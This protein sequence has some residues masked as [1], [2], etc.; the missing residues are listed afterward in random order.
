MAERAGTVFETIFRR[1]FA[2]LQLQEVGGDM[3]RTMISK[4]RPAQAEQSD[5]GHA[6]LLRFEVSS[7]VER[8]L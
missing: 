3:G 5:A 2:N 1:F 4:V 7:E 8:I 6:S